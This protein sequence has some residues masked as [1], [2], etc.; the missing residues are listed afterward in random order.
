MDRAPRLRSRSALLLIAAALL[1]SLALGSAFVVVHRVKD[2]RGAPVEAAS[3]PLSDDQTRDQVV[4]AARQFV[5]AGRLG[6]PN[7][8]YLLQSCAQNDE[9]PY[10]GTA[11]LTFDVPSITK[12]PRYFRD[13]AATMRALGWTEG[14]P[15]RRHPGGKMLA[16]DGV[17]ALLYRDPDVPG[18]GVLQIHGECRNITDHRVDATGFVDITG[19]LAD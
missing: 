6:A 11:Y 9:P 1:L 12:T 2:L 10:Q 15:P 8:S 5:T 13:I 4:R 3:H 16:K 19:Q 18:R 17:T 7:G 14:L